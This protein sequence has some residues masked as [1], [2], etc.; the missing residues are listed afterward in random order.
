MC[1]TT[2]T[3]G[4]PKGVLYSHRALVLHSLGIALPDALDVREAD[5]I[6]PV[7]PMFHA[8]AWG[9]PY[10]AAMVGAKLVLPGPYLDPA[11]LVELYESERVTMTAGVPTIWMGLLQLLDA[12]PGKFDLS[13][14]RA[15]IVGGAAAPQAMIEAFEQ[16]HGLRVIH[17]WGM[18]EMT[19]AGTVSRL[20]PDLETAASEERV[21]LPRQP[22]AAA[23][24]RRH[25]GARRRRPRPLGWRDDG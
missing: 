8:N 22:G 11:S 16:R 19:P 3:T 14:L 4:R 18:T 7:V 25:P 15:L 17:A 23:A 20:A 10:A 9:L 21:P 5:T 24:V 13:R 1:Y 2:G 6:L 12:Q